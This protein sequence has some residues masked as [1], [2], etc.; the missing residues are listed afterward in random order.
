MSVKHILQHSAWFALLIAATCSNGLADDGMVTAAQTMQ[1]ASASEAGPDIYALKYFAERGETEKYNQELTRL[2]LSYPGFQA[3]GDPLN[4]VQG[5][6]QK[7]WTLYGEGRIDELE[8]LIT[9]QQAAQ[10]YWAPDPDLL[11]KIKQY[12]VRGAL[13][14]AHANYDFDKVKQLANS[15][16][17]IITPD[18][19]DT[20]WAVAE[21]LSHEKNGEGAFELYQAML[22]RFSDKDLINAT[23]QKA[24]RYLPLADAGYLYKRVLG[25]G[26]KGSNGSALKISFAR[27]LAIRANAFGFALPVNFDQ[28]LNLFGQQAE[29]SKDWADLQ[30]LAWTSYVSGN[31]D[32]SY[33]FFAQ[34]PNGKEH[35]KA[36]EGRIL[37]LKA[38]GKLHEAQTL[39]REWKGANTDLS[40]LYV[41]L[42][43][44]LLLDHKGKPLTQG[45]LQDYVKHTKAQKS[46]AGAEALGW[47]A[48]NLKQFD[49]SYA[50]FDKA[51]EWQ[52]TETAAYGK[53]LVAAFL[54]NKQAFSDLKALYGEQ[55][56]TV[57]KLTYK[58][59]IQASKRGLG[60]R[61][62]TLDKLSQ[63]HKSGDYHG[64]LAIAEGLIASG[65]AN[66]QTHQTRGWC[67]MQLK[68]PTEA[69]FAFEQSI[70]TA[71]QRHNGRLRA[72]SSY[73]AS[74]AALSRGK[75]RDAE[76]VSSNAGLSQSQKQ[77]IDQGVLAQK[78]TEAFRQKRYLDSLHFLA[79]R[80]Q[81]AREPRN[82]TELRAWSMYHVGDYLAAHRLFVSLN[83]V[84]S[85][86]AVRDGI[87]VT[88]NKIRPSL[89]IH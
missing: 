34:V 62:S 30:L 38:L 88:R 72:T 29:R 71:G 2:R 31:F 74:L 49:T 65:R 80:A 12:R 22:S 36:I 4:P 77:E 23:M 63:A 41:S 39:S 11:K 52:L 51:I 58:S 56:A 83:N 28:E 6:D 46:G 13:L 66:A 76:R 10:P 19:P 48:F 55:Y 73:G 27:G 43:S 44:P 42:F 69:Q 21:A 67:L 57:A 18:D 89:Q 47:Y 8:A 7:Y 3:P 75:T 33:R 20:L 82:L 24:A 40:G 37:S 32:Q 1:V 61:V 86:K 45:F 54:N 68:R 59:Q 70:Q 53:T 50:W 17:Q 60:K 78:A 84:V 79:Q 9:R 87:K 25:A 5:S 15:N 14:K 26:S 81:I 64:C 35:L 85:S 16:S